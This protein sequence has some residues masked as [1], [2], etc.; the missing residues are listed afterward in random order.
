LGTAA[1]SS[2]QIAVTLTSFSLVRLELPC[3]TEMEPARL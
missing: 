3:S 1:L 2:T